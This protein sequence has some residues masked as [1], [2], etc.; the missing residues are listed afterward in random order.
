MTLQ[1]LNYVITITE[2]GSLNKASEILYVAQPS[3]TNAI[4]ELEKEVGIEIFNRSS[5]GVTLTNDGAEFLLYARQIYQQ[6]ESLR[7]KYDKS[8]T[9]KKKFGVSTQHYSFAVKA[10]VEMVKAF[11]TSKYEFAI[12]ETKTVDVISDVNMLRSEIGILYLSDFNHKIIKKL[13]A[14]NDLE[15]HQLIDCQAYVYLWRGHPLANCASITFMQLNDYP[16][17]SFEQG[18]SGSFYFSEEILSVNEYPRTIKACDRAT[19]LNLMVGLNG[20]TLCSGIICEELNGTDYVAIP[21]AADDTNQNNAMQ[22]GYIVK[23]NSLLSEMGKLYIREIKSYLSQHEEEIK[24]AS[25]G[26]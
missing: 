13:L 19:M 18:G 17:L 24:K 3:L 14:A 9:R 11:D 23:K 26:L 12:R 21:F 22:I 16:C 25:K 10:F 15:F 7:D 8:G 4:K 20:Y 6:Y 1:Q 5:K 2:T